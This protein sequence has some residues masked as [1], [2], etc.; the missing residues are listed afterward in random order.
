MKVGKPESELSSDE[1]TKR[2]DEAIGR[3]LNTPPK[4]HTA[5]A[6]A[7]SKKKEKSVEEPA[8]R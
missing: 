5:G 1:I 3:A 4:P 8:R 6:K 7:K 2:R